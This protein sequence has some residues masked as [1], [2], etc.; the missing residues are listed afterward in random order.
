MSWHTP[1]GGVVKEGAV[2]KV[3]VGL[4]QRLLVE[5]TPQLRTLRHHET[6]VAKEVVRVRLHKP[7]QLHHCCC[8][9]MSCCIPL[10][11]LASLRLSGKFCQC[12]AA[13]K[14]LFYTQYECMTPKVSNYSKPSLYTNTL[15]MSALQDLKGMTCLR[16]RHWPA[17]GIHNL[18]CLID[19][20]HNPVGVGVCQVVV[21]ICH[22]H[23]AIISTAVWQCCSAP[24]RAQ[25]GPRVSF[26]PHLTSCLTIAH[27][28]AKSLNNSHL[29]GQQGIHRQTS[30]HLLLRP[31]LPYLAGREGHSRAEAGDMVCVIGAW[32]QH[33]RSALAG[34][35]GRRLLG[36]ALGVCCGRHPLRSCWSMICEMP[37]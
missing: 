1:V 19:D 17:S 33:G 3:V 36:L 13:T 31:A 30:Q 22:L 11:R 14:G 7:H 8:K 15:S 37:K 25:T 6:C 27:C 12:S 32:H 5:R 20:G 35:R 4:R 10:C 29:S 24:N 2:D 28:L 26:W 34:T 21:I 23:R 16:E 9:L 18:R